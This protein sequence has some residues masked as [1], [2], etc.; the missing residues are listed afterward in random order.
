[1]ANRETRR[2]KEPFHAYTE[3]VALRESLAGSIT[4]VTNETFSI[5]GQQ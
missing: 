5:G 3:L 2:Q 1:M 4:T